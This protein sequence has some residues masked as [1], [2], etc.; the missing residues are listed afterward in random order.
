MA[1]AT[2]L[3]PVT[4]ATREDFVMK[5]E[6]LPDGGIDHRDVMRIFDEVV[7]PRLEDIGWYTGGGDPSIAA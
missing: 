3:D 6:E 1:T 7:V 5:L 2:K 4:E